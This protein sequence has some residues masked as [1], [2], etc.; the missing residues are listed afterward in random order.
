VSGH[1]K[2][3][4]LNSS[5]PNSGEMHDERLEGVDGDHCRSDV[6]LFI[7][8]S[9]GLAQ[10]GQAKCSSS[11]YCRMLFTIGYSMDVLIG[12]IKMGL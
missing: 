4:K 10:V 9:V 1:F 11:F 3:L 6:A 12:E 2:K 5:Y 7:Q 8:N